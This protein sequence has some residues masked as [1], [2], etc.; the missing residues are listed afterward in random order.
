VAFVVFLLPPTDAYMDTLHLINPGVMPYGQALA[1]QLALRAEIAAL[2]PEAQRTGYLLCLE[3]PP[4]VTLGKRGQTQDLLNPTFLHEQGV[5]IF[6]IDRGGE[7]TFHEPGQLVVY[8]ILPIKQMNLGVVD[9]IRNMADCMARSV[10]PYGAHVSYNKD[11]P[12]LWTEA[13][14]RSPAMKMASVGMRVSKGITTHGLAIN[15]INPMIGFGW[16]VPCGAPSTPFCNL[17]GFVGDA[18]KDEATRRALFE[19]VRGDFVERFSA[20]LG[21]EATAHARELPAREDWVEPMSMEQA[22]ITQ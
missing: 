2:P 8:P 15:L 6:K 5:E 22:L 11:V 20:Y 13:N 7:A 18:R 14:E 21:V 19:H 12:G 17:L 3:H 9:L 10:A 1:L 16:I 4:T